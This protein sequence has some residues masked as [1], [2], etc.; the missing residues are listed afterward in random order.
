MQKISWEDFQKVNIRVGTI[1]EVKDFPEAKKPAYKIIIDLGP[2]VGIK[3]SSVQITTLYKK[4]ELI[5]KQ[6]ICVC[7]FP[8][9]QIG[10][11]ISEVLT[12]GFANEN[13]AVVLAMPERHVPNGARL[14]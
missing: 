10:P 8:P 1:I 6:I 13:G 4:E 3:H 7:N 12:T 5:N 14:F 11:F 9:K 2:E